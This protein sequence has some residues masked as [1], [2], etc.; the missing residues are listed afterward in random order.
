MGV[1]GYGETTVCSKF[2][3]RLANSVEQG[4][5]GIRI[6]F[7]DIISETLARQ[8]QRDALLRRTKITLDDENLILDI[9][10][11]GLDK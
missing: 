8:F 7:L 2:L 10:K 1:L 11:T 5:S 4:R 3:Q 6:Q 9:G